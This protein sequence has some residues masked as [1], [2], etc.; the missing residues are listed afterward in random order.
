[1]LIEQYKH[2][3]WEGLTDNYLRVEVHGLPAQKQNWQHTVVN[4]QLTHLVDDGV[5]GEYIE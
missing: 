2:D 4:A 3:C 1:M 5:Y